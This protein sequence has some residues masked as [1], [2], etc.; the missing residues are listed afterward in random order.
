MTEPPRLELY[1][2]SLAPATGRDQQDRV[3]RRLYDLDDSGRIKGFDV[4]LCGDCVCPRAETARTDPG[5][6]LLRRYERFEEWADDAGYDLAGF[7]R[8]EVESMLTGT[9]VT[10][11]AFPRMSLAEYRGGSLTFVAPAADG[12]ETVTV[13]DRLDEYL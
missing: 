2:R 11:I 10:G 3:V 9:T 8:R 5:R 12:S 1:L 4:R 7:E 13:Q 6:Q